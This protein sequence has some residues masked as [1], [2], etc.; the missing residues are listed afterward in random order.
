MSPARFGRYIVDWLNGVGV[1]VEWSE[2]A[3]PEG[4][5]KNYY[6]DEDEDHDDENYYGGEHR[7]G[8]PDD[9]DEMPSDVPDEDEENAH[10][11]PDNILDD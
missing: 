9:D 11:Y 4:G 2:P 5:A 6:P 10:G 3:D 7:H 1:K 8:Y